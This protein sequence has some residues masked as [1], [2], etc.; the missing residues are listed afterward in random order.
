MSYKISELVNEIREQIPE[1]VL[2]QIQGLYANSIAAKLEEA[3]MLYS[4]E[5]G[6]R[7]THAGNLAGIFEEWRENDGNGYW[8]V[9][10]NEQGRAL[11]RNFVRQHYPQT[12]R[13]IREEPSHTEEPAFIEEQYTT[14]AGNGRI[15]AR[16]LRNQFQNHLIIICTDDEYCRLFDK[17]AEKFCRLFGLETYRNAWGRSGVQIRRQD[18][19]SYFVHQLRSRF[20]SY[21]IKNGHDLTVCTFSDNAQAD[22]HVE[23]VTVAENPPEERP[24]PEQTVNTEPERDNRETLHTPRTNRGRAI[25]YNDTVIVEDEDGEE[26][27]LLLLKE[28]RYYIRVVEALNNT[29]LMRVPI[30]ELNGYRIIT[31]ETPFASAL[32]GKRNG[33]R[34]TVN[35]AR[36]MIKEIEVCDFI[37]EDE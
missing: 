4:A 14:W 29:E 5:N 32:R 13:Y 6:R 31:P 23:T 30:L 37:D 24:A 34:I 28:E 26:Q 27:K 25:D 8:Q 12:R 9:L 18:L 15:G 20:I 10:Y 2:G 21:A 35:G 7:P 33:E 11:V 3:G 16:S 22:N 36:Y 1:G 19:D 17:S